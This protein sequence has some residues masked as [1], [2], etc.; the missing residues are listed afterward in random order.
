MNNEKQRVSRTWE[1]RFCHRLIVFS[2][3]APGLVMS[4]AQG[5]DARPPQMRIGSIV[6][7]PLGQGGQGPRQRCAQQRCQNV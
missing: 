5:L 3:K 2:E 6:S 1:G 4:L 7:G